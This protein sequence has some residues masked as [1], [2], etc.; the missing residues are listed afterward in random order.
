MWKRGRYG[1]GQLLLVGDVLVIQ[2]EHGD[3]AFVRA[4]HES[5][6]ELNRLPA[7]A[8][9]SWNHPVIWKNLLLV[10]NAQEC[11]CYEIPTEK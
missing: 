11:I 10:R 4:S 9:K 3:I 1:Y 5:Y 7:L 6:Q 8:T 2:A